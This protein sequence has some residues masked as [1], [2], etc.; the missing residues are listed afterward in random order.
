MVHFTGDGHIDMTLT[1]AVADPLVENAIRHTTPDQPITV[2]ISLTDSDVHIRVSNLGAG[3][4]TQLREQLF[5]PWTGRAHGG[6]GL[7]LAREAARS[8][9]GDV[10][11]ETY[12]P[13]TTAFLA[14]LPAP[15][16]DTELSPSQ[17][18]HP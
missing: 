11:C 2:D 3:V 4:A 17:A 13:P 7:W 1:R 12:G 15:S 9:G 10:V 5:Q 8:A 16:V 6:L 18:A 14:R